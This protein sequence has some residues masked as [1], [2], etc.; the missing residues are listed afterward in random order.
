M[1]TLQDEI[2]ELEKLLTAKRNRLEEL[3]SNNENIQSSVISNDIL[4][5]NNLNNKSPPEAK[6]ALFRSLFKGREDIYAKRFESKKTGK[7]GYQPV[8][9]NEWVRGICEKP[10]INCGSC[11]ER[12]FEPVTDEVM[13]LR[14]AEL[15]G[16]FNVVLYQNGGS[17]CKEIY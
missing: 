1:L 6:I 13:S 4:P 5:E 12:A 2:T 11:T 16:I 3:K 7:S 17:F 9:R 15:C 10:K 14:R 8:C